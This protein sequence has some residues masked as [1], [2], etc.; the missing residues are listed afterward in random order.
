MQLE[1]ADTKVKSEAK[2]QLKSSFVI[3]KLTLQ[4]F[5]GIKDFTLNIDGKDCDIFG[6]NATG[7]T[8]IYDA[9]LWVLFS[10]DSQ[11][12]AQFEIKPLTSTGE[13][14]HGVDSSVEGIFEL[15]GEELSLK[16]VHREKW[17][18]TRG[19]A[20]RTFSG[21]ETDHFINSVPVKQNEFNAQIAQIVGDENLFKLLSSVRYFNEILHWTDRRKLLLE[22]CGNLSDEEVISSDISLY[23]LPEIL[24]NRSLDNHRKVIAARKI[25]LNKELQQLPIRLDETTKGLPNIEDFSEEAL[26]EQIEEQRNLLK[27]KEQTLTRIES[28]GEIAEKKKELAEIEAQILEKENS[29]RKSKDSNQEEKLKELRTK[30][31]RIEYESAT[32]EADKTRARADIERIEASLEALRKEWFK[33][34]AEKFEI[35]TSCPTCKQPLPEEM[36]EGARENFNNNKAER[37]KANTESGKT[38]QAAKIALERS[39]EEKNTKI[40]E[41]DNDLTIV[42]EAISRLD[43]EPEKTEFD[44]ELHKLIKRKNAI[45]DDINSLKETNETVINRLKEE[46][47]TIDDSILPRQTQLAS[48]DLYKKGLQRI[49][50]LKAQEK[51][52]AREYER[53]EE[54]LNL[55]DL[56]IKTKVNLLTEKINSKFK[57]AKF[58]LFETQINEGIREVCEVA[59]NGVGYSDLNNGARIQVGMDIIDTL[60]KHYQFY[61]PVIV[62]NAESITSLPEIQSQLIRLIVSKPDKKLRVEVQ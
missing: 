45:Q 25:E 35:S 33:I 8:S 14:I 55:T 19:S 50:E 41:L 3:K 11:N 26:K 6:E 17:V 20:Q 39:I 10:K 32:L 61:A 2:E 34:D 29:L 52:L 15:N 38:G 22:I 21:N 51:L 47:K 30:K 54:E 28:G 36:I 9:F 57:M 23:Q 56:F 13:V 46:I 31:N 12:Q 24:K 59:H 16:K 42:S 4:N 48:F 58:R 53:L 1:L 5:K 49:E 60:A 18:K 37:L 43:K 27:L 7:K 62:D 44:P 40:V